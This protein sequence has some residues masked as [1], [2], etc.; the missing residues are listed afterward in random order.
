MDKR[1]KLLIVG[2]AW[3]PET[4]LERLIHGLLQH[5]IEITIASSKKPGR[6][7]PPG[8]TWLKLPSSEAP[9]PVAAAETLS[10]A[11]RALLL[12][13]R[14]FGKLSSSTTGIAASRFFLPFAGGKWDVIYFPWNSAAVE[15]LP[16]FDLGHATVVS[17]RGAQINIAPHNPERASIR[18]GLE[19]TF[20]K[21]AA[22]HCVSEAI[23]H[24][25]M[26]YG[27]DARKAH[28]IRPAVDADFFSPDREGRRTMD[29]L[30][31]VTTGSLIWR[32]G[33]EYALQAVQSA[34][35]AGVA[36]RF[37]V[38]GDGPERQRVVYTIHD[39]GLHADVRLLG[40]QNS[41][42]VRE[43]LRN[44][45]VFL[46]SSL[47][48]GISNAALEGMSCGLPVVTTECGGMREAV[49]DG[50]E[51]FV[52]PVRDPEAMADALVKLADDEGLR[53]RMGGNARA[54]IEQAFSIRD[55]IGKWL[56]LLEHAR[57]RVG[58]ERA[59]A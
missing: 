14:D 4:F 53:K 17:C 10:G 26:K 37:D 58:T 50:V 55:Q 59:A 40:S 20:R 5:G 54:R 1:L 15:Y 21:A 47:S 32:K 9:P 41:E 29:S 30:R 34:K 3:P 31:V 46:L 23:M 35:K 57:S 6:D 28:V 19:E 44:A 42:S 51:G 7:L 13:R 22:I 43:H 12:S 56:S 39:L 45:D 36:I 8:L 52:V 2:I 16:L 25:A 27:L 18:Q 24:E 33:F 48:E 49:D 11:V 38:I